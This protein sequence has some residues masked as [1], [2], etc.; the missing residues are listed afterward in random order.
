[1]NQ[2]AI[3]EDHLFDSL[4]A[5]LTFAY[6]YSGQQYSPS[7]MAKMMRGSGGSGKGLSGLD[8]AA[9]AGLIRGL[10]S[11]LDLNERNVI[12]AKFSADEAESIRAK[13][14]LALPVMACLTTG[15]HSR[16]AVGSLIQKWFGC[17]MNI[18]DTAEKL[19][20]HRNTIGPMWRDVRGCLNGIWE[21]A[22]TNAHWE[23]QKAGLI[24]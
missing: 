17:K 14:A 9:Q 2:S 16:H 3:A 6:R 7:I 24:P 13:L 12:A 22:E 21:R 4:H 11:N 1:M 23:L 19:K 15:V 18:Q 20:L 8:G 10:L 5:A